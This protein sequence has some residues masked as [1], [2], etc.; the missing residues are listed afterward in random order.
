MPGDATRIPA[1]DAPGDTA[2]TGSDTAAPRPVKRPEPAPLATA[3]QARIVEMERHAVELRADLERERID[4]GQERERAE[5]LV[6]EVAD[7]ARQLA[8]VVDEAASRER[9]LQARLVA[10]DDAL[11][12]TRDEMVAAQRQAEAEAVREE[13]AAWKS[14][15]WWRRLAG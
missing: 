9:E 7:L 4:R 3:L 6:G 2:R 15:P 14:R 11:A 13:F 8:R 5:H 10:A 12:S 1:G